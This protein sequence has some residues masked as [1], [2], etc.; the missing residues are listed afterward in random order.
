MLQIPFSPA[1]ASCCLAW[2]SSGPL[3]TPYGSRSHRYLPKGVWNVVAKLDSWC[4][5]M[6]VKPDIASATEK[7]FAPCSCGKMSSKRGIGCLGTL[8]A[9]LIVFDGS[10]QILNLSFVSLTVMLL[11]QAVGSYLRQTFPSLSILSNS[12]LIL[13]CRATGCRWMASWTGVTVGSTSKETGRPNS[14]NPVCTSGNASRTHFKVI[15]SGLAGGV[16]FEWGTSNIR[17]DDIGSGCIGMSLACELSAV[18][19]GVE[20]SVWGFCFSQH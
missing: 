18:G 10:K 19:R 4:R 17:G 6:L 15:V 7:H 2:Y 20:A 3:E 1:R 9:L 12:S 11:H 13:A 8:I 5:S 14:P 16:V